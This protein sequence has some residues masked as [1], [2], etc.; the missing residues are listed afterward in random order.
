[1]PG[2]ELKVPFYAKVTI[3]LVGII[4]LLAIM[5]I[6]KGIIIPVVFAIIIAIV[7]HP[8]VNFMVRLKINRPVWRILAYTG[9]EVYIASKPEY[10]RCCRLFQ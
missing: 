6:A 10:C 7:L 4:A 8:V 2:E 9:R 1:V 3:L 5:Y